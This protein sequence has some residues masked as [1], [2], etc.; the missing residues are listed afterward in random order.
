MILTLLNSLLSPAHA[1]C[2]TFVGGAGSDIYNQYSQAAIV[3]Y[4]NQ[5]TLTIQNDVQGEF[6]DFAMV[7][8]VPSVLPEDAIHVIEPTVFDGLDSYSQPR[9]VRYECSDFE[10]ELENDF[11]TAEEDAGGYS[12]T[13]YGG[14]SVEA[15][16]IVGEYDIIILS[17]TESDNL[18]DW[19]NDNGYQLP[20]QSIPM[21]EQYINAGSFFLA[22]KVSETAGIQSGDVLSPLQFQ[23]ESEAFGLPIRIGTLNSKEA[24][25]LVLYVINEYWQGEAKIAN[26]P[27]FTVE[28]ECMWESQ[29][30]EF[31]QFYA[32]TFTRG[33]EAQD[34]GTFI[35]EYSWGGGGCDPCTGD[36][37]SGDDLIS[38]GVNEE[39]I[40]YSD[41]Y[42]TRLHMR[43]TPEEADEDLML[44]HSNLTTTSQIRYIEYE[45][46][47]EDRFP[48][49]GEGMVDNPGSCESFNTFEGDRELIKASACG[50]C[51]AG[52]A[53]GLLGIWFM[54][55]LVGLRRRKD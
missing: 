45:E 16:Y 29:G 15:Q 13:G 5:T 9:L 54:G 53:E 50:G 20:G 27:E 46:F 36:P 32:D 10:Y 25:D 26:Y 30:E 17:A 6:T 51:S 33:Y 48:V 55:S 18:F 39:S 31:G 34:D 52:G 3:R 37:P 2:G 28:D 1:F 12:D 8:P 23:Y 21:L 35:V 49:C 11:A 44:Y 41:Y 24:Q 14:V 38:L 22:A 19:L 40:H 4:G 7:I 42:F 47:L 43:Y